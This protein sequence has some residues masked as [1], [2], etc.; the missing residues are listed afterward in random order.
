MLSEAQVS[1]VPAPRAP[2]PPIIT[3]ADV[4]L[5]V[6]LYDGLHLAI[7]MGLGMVIE[8]WTAGETPKVRTIYP[9][10]IASSRAGADIV[11]AAD[12]LRPG[13]PSFRVDR[14]RRVL[15]FIR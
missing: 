13:F 1:Y 3:P 4:T 12:S 10:E 8:Y 14:I 5:T 11:R 6:A 15:A 9:V 7:G 2:A